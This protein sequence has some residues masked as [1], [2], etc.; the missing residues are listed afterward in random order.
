MMHSTPKRSVFARCAS[1]S[2]MLLLTLAL[3]ST[4]SAAP[5]QGRTL[6]DAERRELDA[7]CAKLLAEN[8]ALQAVADT[9][10][11]SIANL[12]KQLKIAEALVK[13]GDE[14][15]ARYDAIV[16][17][18]KQQIADLQAVVAELKAQIAGNRE[19]IKQLRDQVDRGRWA[20]L[21]DVGLAVVVTAIV[22]TALVFAAKGGNP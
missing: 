8:E 16:A 3:C 15:A 6:T 1:A 17:L 20:R 21:R 13:N 7:R 10:E 9:Q 19:E 22:T 12:T 2:L 5:K 11:A 4:T 14:M 18:Y